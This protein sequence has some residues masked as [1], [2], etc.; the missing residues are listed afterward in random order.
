MKWRD[1]FYVDRA[2]PF[3]GASAPNIFNR[4][5]DLLCWIFCD[6]SI[7]FEEDDHYHY[8]DDFFSCG[9]PNSNQCLNGL[10]DCL[11]LAKELGVEIE[12]VKTFLTTT[13]CLI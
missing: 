12:R 1:K 11:E 10:N 5:A 7:H 6:N 13:R 9:Q 3:G 4:S 8:Y 2:L